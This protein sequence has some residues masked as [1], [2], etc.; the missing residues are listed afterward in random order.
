ME[1]SALHPSHRLAPSPR[2][3]RLAGDDRLVALIRADNEAAFEVVYD[4]YHPQ[5]L[6]FCP[7]MPGHAEGADD[8]G[9]PAFSSAPAALQRP[10]RPTAPRAWRLPVA[11][12]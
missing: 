8:P 2:M 9:P 4:R 7:H 11:A 5:L 12:N 6:S 1:A 3:L 10:A